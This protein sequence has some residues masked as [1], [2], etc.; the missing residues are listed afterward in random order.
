[1]LRLLSLMMMLLSV[2]AEAAVPK[3]YSTQTMDTGLTLVGFES[4][5]VPLV[6]IVLAAKAGAMT[7]TADSN[8]LTHLWE[9]MFFKGNQR[10]PNQEAF[11]KRIRQLGITYNG[12]TSA[13][14]V[15]YF[16]TLPSVFL[17]EGLQFMADAIATP[18]L[19]QSEMERER[20]VVLNEYER[21][22]AQPAFDFMNL[23]RNMI[24]GPLGYRRDPLGLAP[25][26][27]NATREQLLRIKDQV[28]VPANC[29]L[30]VG[31]DFVPADL[32]KLAK[33]HFAN[34][35]TPE[36]WKPLQPP[37]FPRFPATTSFV[38]TRPI[39]QNVRIQ[40]T[41]DG[42]KVRQQPK[43]T[44]PLDVL[45]NLLEHRGGKFYQK[46]VDS[47]LAYEAG[48]SYYTQSQAG[49]IDL[50]ATAAPK[51]AKE[52][53]KKLIAEI[54]E[55]INP[56]YFNDAQLVDVKRKMTIHRKREQNSPTEFIKELAFWWAVTGLDYYDSYLTNID[57][58]K[59]KDVQ[60]SVKNWVLNAPH[61]DSV[62]LSPEDARAVGLKDTSA[63]LAEK[64]L[65]MYKRPAAKELPTAV[66][67]ESSSSPG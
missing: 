60:A 65:E 31:G 66:A 52:V 5:K 25:I 26:I 57:K 50:Y 22:A 43:E 20:R 61:L 58:V 27:S 29:A 62:L 44:Y 28:F 12:D 39:V 18:L 14:K 64:Y 15:R 42:P 35:R 46:F 40:S 67:P 55:W 47:G 53:Q 2:N 23:Q 17:E 37:A 9:H 59:L 32:A 30:L 10:L 48:F 34:W 4:H 7:E 54:K 49:E 41:F 6:T 21:N 11:N 63:P 16:I 36:G 24:Y 45:V 51:R 13:E 1:M 19:E 56:G 3:A 33:K 38:M 8:G